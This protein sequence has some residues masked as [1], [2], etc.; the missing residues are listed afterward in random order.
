MITSSSTCAK[1]T[2]MM[3]APSRLNKASNLERSEDAVYQSDSDS[4]PFAVLRVR[5][6]SRNLTRYSSVLRDAASAVAAEPGD[7]AG[8]PQVMA[9]FERPHSV[10]CLVQAYQR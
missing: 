4:K 6:P 2:A 8:A 1:N 7:A 9:A 5:P 3:V 10:H